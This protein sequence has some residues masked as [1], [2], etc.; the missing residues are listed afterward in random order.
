MHRN[1]LINPMNLESVLTAVEPMH[2]NGEED[3]M[4]LKRK[5]LLDKS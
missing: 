2:Q 4:A 3:P 1:V 5:N